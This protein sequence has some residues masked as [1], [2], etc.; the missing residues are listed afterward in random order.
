[1][2]NTNAAWAGL[3]SKPAI[4]D[5]IPTTYRWNQGRALESLTGVRFVQS[6]QTTFPALWVNLSGSLQRAGLSPQR[7]G[8]GQRWNANI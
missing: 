8:L 1:M 7:K 4:R 6:D 2:Y 3:G 5:Q